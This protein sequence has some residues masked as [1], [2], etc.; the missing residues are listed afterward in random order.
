MW[1]LSISSFCIHAA[2]E[3]SARSTKHF[4][5]LQPDTGVDPREIIYSVASQPSIAANG[6]ITE[7][8]YPITETRVRYSDRITLQ[9]WRKKIDDYLSCTVVSHE[10]S[11]SE[12]GLKI[13]SNLPH[14]ITRLPL[15]ELDNLIPVRQNCQKLARI[16]PYF[17][18][19]GFISQ[20]RN[21]IIYC[22]CK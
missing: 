2:Y 3:N 13:L 10:S 16:S 14:F 7:F 17:V 15:E 20:E 18:S 19:L 6:L 12:I 5:D 9:K 11:R 4:I 1:L 21:K 22:A 8:N